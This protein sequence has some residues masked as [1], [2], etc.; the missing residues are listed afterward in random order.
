MY[1]CDVCN[2]FFEE[3]VEVVYEVHTELPGTPKEYRSGCPIC[4]S[5]EIEKAYICDECGD[6]IRASEACFENGNVYCEECLEEIS[7]EMKEVSING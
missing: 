7:C 6:S 3:P 2:N 4:F 1:Y 5:I